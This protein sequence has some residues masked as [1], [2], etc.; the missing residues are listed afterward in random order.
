MSREFFQNA[1]TDIYLSK[2]EEKGEIL[3]YH[4][5]GYHADARYEEWAENA[6]FERIS[7]D[8]AGD[9]I[10]EVTEITKEAFLERNRYGIQVIH[11][12]GETAWRGTGDSVH[13]EID[14]QT[15]RVLMKEFEDVEQIAENAGE[16]VLDFQVVYDGEDKCI[17][18]VTG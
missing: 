15:V 1:G 8:G 3:L 17:F 6:Y 18:A 4:W 11:T 16:A 2:N 10:V 12:C 14:Y 9:K 13:T 5:Q 7:L